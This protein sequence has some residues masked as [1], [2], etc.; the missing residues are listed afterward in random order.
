[1]ASHIYILSYQTPNGADHDAAQTLRQSLNLDHHHIPHAPSRPLCIHKAIIWASLGAQGSP[2]TLLWQHGSTADSR[3]ASQ[4]SF[5]LRYQLHHQAIPTVV[6]RYCRFCGCISSLADGS[7]ET[8]CGHSG[9]S[10]QPSHVLPGADHP[11]TVLDAFTRPRS[12][13]PS[14]RWR[15]F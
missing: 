8:L 7:L 1:M 2:S 5:Q 3:S 4:S 12:S 10:N 13:V 15:C 14:L 9:M 6:K 11:H